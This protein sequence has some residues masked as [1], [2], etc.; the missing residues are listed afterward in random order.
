VDTCLDAQNVLSLPGIPPREVE[1]A[2][3]H[4]KDMLVV[5][6]DETRAADESMRTYITDD[7]ESGDWLATVSLATSRP[8]IKSSSDN[9]H[10]EIALWRM[11]LQELPSHRNPLTELRRASSVVPCI[12]LLGRKV[13]DVPATSAAPERMFSSGGN[14]MT[15]KRARLSCDHLEELMYLYEVW[16]EVREWTAIK[17]LAWRSAYMP[18][19]RVH[20]HTNTHAY[21]KNPLGRIPCFFV[22]TNNKYQ[23]R[24]HLHFRDSLSFFYKYMNTSI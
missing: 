22:V 10:E 14:I 13:L 4:V 9:A 19:T 11:R 17:K 8:L 5:L 24:N 3:K 18:P 7:G 6:I 21:T 16:L 15:K 1:A 23:K 20:T 2:W 12:V